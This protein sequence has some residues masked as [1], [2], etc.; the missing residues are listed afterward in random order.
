MPWNLQTSVVHVIRLDNSV[1]REFG[2]VRVGTHIL[3]IFYFFLFNRFNYNFKS[4]MKPTG[5]ENT[6]PALITIHNK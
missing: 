6:R 4:N 2:G 1:E 5:S 3:S